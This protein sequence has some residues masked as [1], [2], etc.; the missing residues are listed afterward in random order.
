M[1]R[2]FPYSRRSFIQNMTFIGALI[3][4]TL[5]LFVLIDAEILYLTIIIILE[6]V[7][8]VVL[9]VSPLLTAHE[10]VDGVLVLHQGWYFRARIPVDDIRSIA[11]LDRG[12][13]RTGVFFRVLSATLFVTSRRNDLIELRL[14]SKRPF[15][16][17]LGKKAD[18]VVFDVEDTG[19][20]LQALRSDV[21]FT[22]IDA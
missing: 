20:M 7:I 6:V 11:R 13:S 19:A 12:P 21:L 22:P 14:R 2:S 10:I 4:A 5:A 18:R 3:P 8:F 1:W 15:G 17:A 16:W 9:G